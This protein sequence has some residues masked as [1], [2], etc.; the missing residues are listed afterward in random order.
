MV[1]QKRPPALAGRS[2]AGPHVLGDSGLSDFEAELQKLAMDARCAPER[3]VKAH[4]A[5]Q[6]P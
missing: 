4:L 2:R 6:R 3:V 1:A 5:D